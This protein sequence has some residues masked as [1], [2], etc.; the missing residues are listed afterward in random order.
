MNDAIASKIEQLVEYVDILK[1][2]QLF[3]R[4]DF[5]KYLI[6]N[7]YINGVRDMSDFI[8]RSKGYLFIQR[9][10]LAFN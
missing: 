5:H 6:G 8:E 3:K 2:Y 4:E 1:S 9:I 7:Y 10:M